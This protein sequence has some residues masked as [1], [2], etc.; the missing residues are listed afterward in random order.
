VLRLV[1]ASVQV[2]GAAAMLSEEGVEV[3]LRIDGAGWVMGEAH[4]S[5]N[6]RR[7]AILCGWY[8]EWYGGARRTTSDANGIE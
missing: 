8:R 4:G 7:R 1:Y 2:S 6:L 3:G 5:A